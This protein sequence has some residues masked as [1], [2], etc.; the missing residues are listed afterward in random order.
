M[1]RSDD[2]GQLLAAAHA[3]ERA[4]NK[5]TASLRFGT[6]IA[7]DGL[8]GTNQIQVGTEVFEDLDSLAGQGALLLAPGDKVLIAVWQNTYTVLGSVRT[9][10]NFQFPILGNPMALGYGIISQWPSCT[11][12]S[13]V[14]MFYAMPEAISPNFL[15]WVGTSVGASTTA[16]FR[17]LIDGVQVD[18]SSVF[19]TGNGQYEPTI[20]WPANVV[21]GQS[22]RVSV[23]AKRISGTGLVAASA[24]GVFPS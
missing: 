17:T 16:Q 3:A 2:T 6:V 15:V 1:P 7:W 14:E 12:A 9:G 19:V 8:N 11:S 10:F 23:Q 18:E 24:L 20:P 22:P 13:Y 21:A 5:L 4:G